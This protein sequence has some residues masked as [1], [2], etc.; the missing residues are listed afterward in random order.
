MPR[1]RLMRV[2][3]PAC[4]GS[5]RRRCVPRPCRRHRGTRRSRRAAA[6]RKAVAAATM[7]A[8]SRLVSRAR[9][10]ATPSGRSVV[11]RITTTGVPS[12]MASSCTPPLSVST[13]AARS[14][15]V[16]KAAWSSGS[17]STRLATPSSR[18]RS[19]DAAAFG[20]RTIITSAPLSRAKRFRAV[21]MACI[22]RAF[23]RR[24]AVARI[25][26]RPSAAERIGETMAA[27]DGSSA[28]RARTAASASTI[29]LPVISVVAGSMHS[30]LK[31]SAAAGVG[32]KCS[33]A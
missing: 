23:S 8:G 33:D 31:E 17:M 2:E 19:S 26:G 32:A 9:P 7:A 10:Q 22:S 14:I 11:S 12:A 4:R 21:A 20:C 27:N 24:C 30:R 15:R 5:A 13:R 1:R 18:A 25:S 3:S 28:T 29:V 6:A 16:T